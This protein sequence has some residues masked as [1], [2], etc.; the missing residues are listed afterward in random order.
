MLNLATTTD[1]LDLIT[2]SAATVDVHA[3]WVD[4]LNPG[5]A[6]AMTP[7]K[8][9]TAISSATTTDIVPSPAANTVRNVKFISIRNRDASLGC[10]VTVRYN[11]NA[12]IFQLQKVT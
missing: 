10:D 2:S 8:T 6:D 4:D 9:N 1:K 5:T 12:T 3:S 7:G 11:Q